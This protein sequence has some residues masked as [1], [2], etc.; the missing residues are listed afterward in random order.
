MLSVW[1]SQL[2][3]RMFVVMAREA[4]QVCG[5]VLAAGLSLS[6]EHK[7]GDKGKSGCTQRHV[8]GRQTQVNQQGWVR[9]HRQSIPLPTLL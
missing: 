8:A 3:C 7:G 1:H 5:M 6:A 2:K 4:Q 9:R